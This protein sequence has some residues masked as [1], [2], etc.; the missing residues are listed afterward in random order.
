MRDSAR[1]LRVFISIPLKLMLN[2]LHANRTFCHFARCMKLEN[3]GHDTKSI[4]DIFEAI[5]GAYYTEKGFE[6]VHVWASRVYEVLIRKASVAFDDWSVLSDSR[7][8]RSN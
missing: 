3:G 6:A 7:R 8:A 1:D 2:V 5:I 4:G